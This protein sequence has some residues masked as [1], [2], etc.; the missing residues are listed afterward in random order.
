MRLRQL[1]LLTFG[2]G[3]LITLAAAGRSAPIVEGMAAGESSADVVAA[4]S[5]WYSI[6]DN[7]VV[8]I[9]VYFFWSPTCP[10]CARAE[11][12]IEDLGSSTPWLDLHAHQLV[13]DEPNNV[14]LA[15]ALRDE[16]GA[17]WGGSVPAFMACETLDVG[18]DEP[19][20]TGAV[21]EA[22]WA[23]CQQDLQELVDATAAGREP[24][25]GPL[26][27]SGTAETATTETGAETVRVPLLGEIDTAA[28]S[29]PALTVVL[30]G[31]DAFN[32][33]AFFVLLFL[34]SLLVH[35]RSRAQMAI[36]GGIFV[37]VSGFAY[38][39]FMAA[40][41]NLFQW[42]GPLRWVTIIAGLVAVT[43]GVVN[44]KDFFLPQRGVSLSIPEGRRPGM[45]KRMRVLTTATSFPAMVAGATT[46]AIA[47]NS[48]EL[49]CTAGLPLVFTRTLTLR[50]LPTAGHYGYIALY[51][52]VYVIPLLAIVALFVW[53][54]GSRK[55]SETE[56]RV[57]KLLS[58]MM[59]TALGLVLLLA[60]EWLDNAVSA[61]GVVVGAAVLTTVIALADR[62][63]RRRRPVPA[64]S[65]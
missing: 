13:A 51:C 42:L 43:A 29:L 21:L 6:D 22:K 61:V 65:R 23:A 38:F 41:L 45:F 40:W 62:R 47:V 11:P 18:F 64:R 49:L 32:P 12:W 48:Y 15:I 53:R 44:M 25:M 56:G 17:E 63:I 37:L 3:A 46:L 4:D 10:H 24:A 36:I 26:A 50:D 39:A 20:T 35:A 2:V 19:D 30:A 9:R 16:I 33:C 55:L 14:D 8:H 60:P 34:L 54:L 57:L 28:W 7:G 31:F 1:A 5:R 52:A 59:M 58:G 27:P